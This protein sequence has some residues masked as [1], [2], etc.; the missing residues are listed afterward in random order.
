MEHLITIKDKELLAELNEKLLELI[1]DN[2]LSGRM[3]MAVVTRYPEGYKLPKLIRSIVKKH[4]A[5]HNAY[6]MAYADICNVDK[7]SID[8]LRDML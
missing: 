4:V 1:Y 2:E 8:E 6:L 7:T 5:K 3:I